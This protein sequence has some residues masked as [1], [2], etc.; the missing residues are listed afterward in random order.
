MCVC[1]CVCVCVSVCL[2]VCALASEVFEQMIKLISVLFFFFLGGGGCR[3][4][5][6]LT[7]IFYKHDLLTFG[8]SFFFF[9]FSMTYLWWK[10]L[11]LGG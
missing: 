9:F 8:I 10:Q 11:T 3:Q 1:V 5:K 2:C 7:H 4:L 6:Q